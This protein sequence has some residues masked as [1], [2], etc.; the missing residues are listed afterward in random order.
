INTADGSISQR[1]DYDEFGN[2]T[3]DT[4]PGFQ[5][6]AFAGGAYDPHTKLIRFGARDYDSEIGRWTAKDPIA[7]DGGDSNLYGYVLDDPINQIDEDGLSVYPRPKLPDWVPDWLESLFEPDAFDL[8]PTPLAAPIGKACKLLPRVAEKVKQRAVRVIG[9][10]PDTAVA[11]NWPG[12]K[13]LDVAEY[14]EEINDKWV[15]EAV[16]NRETIYIGSPLT[17][18]NLTGTPF[19]REFRQFLEAGYKQIGHYLL[20]PGP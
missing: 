15:K 6:F 12:H 10:L 11:K 4:S 19:G 2:I 7:F 17:K 14:S 18:D 13:I 5:P 1:L 8:M 9:R 3:Q 20:P 16:E